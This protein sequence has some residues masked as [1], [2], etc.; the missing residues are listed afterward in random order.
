MR[1]VFASIREYLRYSR[2]F[3][4]IFAIFAFRR[5]HH[6]HYSRISYSRRISK[7]LFATPLIKIESNSRCPLSRRSTVVVRRPSCHPT[8]HTFT[9]YIPEMSQSSYQSTRYINGILILYQ[10]N[11]IIIHLF[12]MNEKNKLNYLELS[13]FP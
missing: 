6:N 10:L 7:S 12:I 11:F 2:L 1:E 3:A 9:T 5:E 8:L 13:I 4:A